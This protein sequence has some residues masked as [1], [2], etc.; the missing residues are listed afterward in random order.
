MSRRH[1]A[2]MPGPGLHFSSERFTRC[3]S[4]I[5]IKNCDPAVF[6]RLTTAYSEPVRHY[7]TLAHIT[8]S[9]YEFDRLIGLA[10][11]PHEIEMAIWF[12][13]AV[14]DPKA[15]DNEERSAEWAQDFFCAPPTSTRMSPR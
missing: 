15:H 5:G 12:H 14:Y 9:L 10:E 1:G 7:H 11:A 6:A 13:D 4:G 3:T 2:S 8:D